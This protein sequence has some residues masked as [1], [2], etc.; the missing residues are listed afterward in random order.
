MFVKTILPYLVF[1]DLFFSIISFVYFSYQINKDYSFLCKK[2]NFL[3]IV[4]N[5]KTLI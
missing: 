2:I 3:I 4:I 5:M 1:D